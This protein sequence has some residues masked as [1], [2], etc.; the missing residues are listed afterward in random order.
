[1]SSIVRVRVFNG[2]LAYFFENHGY[3]QIAKTG[4]SEVKPQTL[5]ERTR[6]AKQTI[7]EREQIDQD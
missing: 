5:P 6:N 3:A 1:M 7:V 4:R 2:H